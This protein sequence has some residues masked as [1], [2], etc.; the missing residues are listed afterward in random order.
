MKVYENQTASKKPLVSLRVVH[1]K[2]VLQGPVLYC[3][4]CS[5]GSD[6]KWFCSLTCCSSHVL[7]HTEQE[8]PR[9]W[10]DVPIHLFREDRSCLD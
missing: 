8:L 1:Y 4:L 2:A 3:E 5:Q 6:A 10:L 9:C 7:I